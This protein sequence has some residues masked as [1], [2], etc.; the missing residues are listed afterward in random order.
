MGHL[1]W[2]YV[3]NRVVGWGNIVRKYLEPS[4]LKTKLSNFVSDSRDGKIK[5]FFNRFQKI[6]IGFQ[7][8][9]GELPY[10]KKIFLT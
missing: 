9:K 6:K 5:M 3:G 7:Y 2:I 10:M 4:Q 1:S 8:Y